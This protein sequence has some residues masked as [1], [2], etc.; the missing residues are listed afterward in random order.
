MTANAT[1]KRLYLLALAVL[2]VLGAF[3]GS[4]SG[5]A[6]GVTFVAGPARV[7]QG[8]EATMT[9]AVSPGGGRC[10]L[11]VRYESGARQKG[12]PSVS[13][14]SGQATWTW[15]VPRLVQPGMAHATASC[16]GA[17]RA[18]KT[19]TVIGQVL[20]PKIDVA[21]SGWSVR[22]YP[23]GGGTVSYGVILSNRSRTQDALDVEVLVN[24]VMADN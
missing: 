4:A 19:F 10:S 8:N 6:Q 9:V 7:V 21:K 12:L 20:P 2:A 13:A 15:K 1:R 17:G 3:A 11:A 14:A 24:F 5:R 16:S 18:S 23:Y 22:T